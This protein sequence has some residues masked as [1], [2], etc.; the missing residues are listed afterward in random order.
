MKQFF[1]FLLI[2]CTGVSLHCEET[3]KSEEANIYVDLNKLELSPES[4]INSIIEDVKSDQTC[5]EEVYY[6]LMSISDHE[7]GIK[8]HFSEEGR[9]RIQPNGD[10][11]IGYLSVG[12]DTIVVTGK[13]L[14]D[15]CLSKGNN[16]IQVF[17]SGFGHYD[18]PEWT[19]LITDGIFARDAEALRWIWHIPIEDLNKYNSNNKFFVTAP[20]RTKK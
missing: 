2:M 13:K 1:F 9:R 7:S 11:Y 15:F 12:K 3:Y 5:P 10:Q 19:Y 8:V 4:L 17:K 14:N 20:K 6:Y 16:S 18:G